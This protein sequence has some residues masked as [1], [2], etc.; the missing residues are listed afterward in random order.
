[1]RN[2]TG[3]ARHL[4]S[5][6]PRQ[7]LDGLDE[8]HVFVLHQEGNGGAVFAATEAV[9]ELLYL[10]D[11]ERRGLF[12]VKR[13][14]GLVFAAGLFQGHAVVDDLDDVRAV[15]KFVDKGLWDTPGHGD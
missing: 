13:A 15:E 12:A 1:M 3:L 10:A 11:R 9:I 8:L 4:E 6:A 5:G 14:A 7:F 2:S